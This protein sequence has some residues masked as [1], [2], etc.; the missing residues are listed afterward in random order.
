MRQSRLKDPF[1]QLLPIARHAGD[2]IMA[3]YNGGP[4]D[5]YQKADNSPVTEA[6][7]AAH[8]VL[9]KALSSLSPTYPVVSEED[10]SSLAH[11]HN[12]GSFWLIDPLDGT[13]EFIARNGEFTVN[14]AL[15]E[16]GR[17]VLGVVYAPAID[18]MYWGGAG[19][20]AFKVTA[21]GTEAIRVS[22]EDPNGICRVV[23]SKSHLNVETRAFIHRLGSV[24]LVQAGSSLKFCRVAEGM[25]DIYPRLAPTCEWDTA[26]A[27]AVLEGA[28]GV[29]LDQEGNPLR[30]GK[31]EVL[32]SCFIAARSAALIPS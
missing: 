6:D 14:I 12:A 20:G 11:R 24:S 7:L 23:A 1:T 4:S 3:V 19:L 13:K 26:A 21:T 25:A 15:I 30:Y 29:V 22:S 8:V 31:P 17:A 16:Q 28:G 18:C 9:A 2:A 5:V 10:E 27:Q 32:N